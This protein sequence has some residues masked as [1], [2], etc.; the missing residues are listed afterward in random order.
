MYSDSW[1]HGGFTIKLWFLV[2]TKWWEEQRSPQNTRL[3]ADNLCTGGLNMGILPPG[4]AMQRHILINA[5]L[6]VAYM[7]NLPL[8]MQKPHY[9]SQRAWKWSLILAHDSRP[10]CRTPTYFVVPLHL[11]P[12]NRDTSR[13]HYNASTTNGEHAINVEK[14]CQ[15]K[16]ILHHPQ[17]V[18]WLTSLWSA[19]VT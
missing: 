12:I 17:F 15:G 16:V 7:L 5:I 2:K 10:I 14:L 4:F 13:V 18:H 3:Q 8:T 1:I 19:I 6:F 9:R 11:D